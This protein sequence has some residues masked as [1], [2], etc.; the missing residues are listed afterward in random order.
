LS[1]V[2][3]GRWHGALAIN[4]RMDGGR[5]TAER[6]DVVTEQQE[7]VTKTDSRRLRDMIGSIRQSLPTLGYPL[8]SYLRDLEGHLARTMI[9]PPTSVDADTVT[10]N[11]KVHLRDLDSGKSQVVTLVYEADAD[12]YGEKLSVL[13]GLGASLL[14]SRVGDVVEWRT[15]RGSRRLR[16]DRILF[17]PEAAGE[18][19]L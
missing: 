14:G 3:N 9:V 17:Q 10:M 4:A 1:W 5:F 19:D 13:T 16:V 11:S 6:C 7:V 2:V 18:F 12:L 8:E 15:R